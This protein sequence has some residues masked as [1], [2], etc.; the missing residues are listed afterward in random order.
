MEM[1]K[2]QIGF[3]NRPD[4][5]SGYRITDTASVR[6]KYGSLLYHEDGELISDGVKVKVSNT[7]INTIHPVSLDTECCDTRPMPGALTGEEQV[8]TSQL[9]D[10]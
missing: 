7:G 4:S 8:E 9:R 1:L 5:H 3:T 10:S 6:R 2:K